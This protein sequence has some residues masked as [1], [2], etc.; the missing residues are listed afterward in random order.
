MHDKWT[1]YLAINNVEL[2]NDKIV[3]MSNYSQK[4]VNQQET[5]AS[6]YQSLIYKLNTKTE[7]R[8]Q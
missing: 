1:T 8:R 2:H 7:Y 3:S 5:S 6:R 4:Q